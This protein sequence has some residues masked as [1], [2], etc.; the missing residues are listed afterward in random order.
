M[1][2]TVEEKQPENKKVKNKNKKTMNNQNES[3][4]LTEAE[5]EEWLK[6]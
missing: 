4:D 3:K 5:N 1:P 2:V 6:Q